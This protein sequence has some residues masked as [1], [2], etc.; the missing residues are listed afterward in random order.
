MKKFRLFLIT[1]TLIFV[2]QHLSATTY[3]SCTNGNWASNST[4]STTSYTSSTNTG[5]YPKA[6]DIVYIGNNFTV[7]I[8]AVAACSTLN[9]VSTLYIGGYN[10]T[11]SG[12]TTISG[13]LNVNAYSGTKIFT[14]LVTVN[15]GGTWNNSANSPVTF[16]GGI[17]NNGTF[18]GTGNGYTFDTNPQSLTGTFDMTG[19]PVVV[20]GITLTNNGTLTLSGNVSGTG[21]LANTSILNST[22][23]ITIAA[24]TNSGTANISAGNLTPTTL[25][26]TGTLN[27]SGT[28]Y[29]SSTTLTNSGT[30]NYTASGNLGAGSTSSFTNTGT[31]NLNGS[32]Y[33]PGITNSTGGIVNFMNAVQSMGTL[34]NN[35]ST[36]ILNISALTTNESFINTLTA[37]ATGNTVNYNGTGSQVIKNTTYYYLNLNGS[38]TKYCLNS[39][40]SAS[41]NITVNTD[42]TLVLNNSNIMGN[43]SKIILNGGTF[44]TGSSS[45]YTETVGTLTLSNNST[46]ALGTGSHSLSFA[47]SSSTTWS[48]TLTITGW[49]GTAGSSGTSG[50]IYVGSDATGLTPYQ[51]S[52]ITF[53][54]YSS[55]ATILS[56]GEVVP[57][58]SALA[59]WYKGDGTYSGGT[60]T[61]VSGKG[62]NAATVSETRT[63]GTITLADN[64]INFNPSLSLSNAVYKLKTASSASVQSVI[65][66]NQPTTSMAADGGLFGYCDYNTG[67]NEI[68]IRM[69]YT[70]QDWTGE[71]NSNDWAYNGSSRING[72]SGY[73]H[74]FKWNIINQIAS[75]AKNYKYYIGGYFDVS[76]GSTWHPRPFYGNVAE[77][78]A[79][80][81]VV[82]NQNNVESYLAVKYGITLSHDYTNGSNSTI[83]SV[84][85]YGYDIAGLGK[86]AT[87]GLN[88]KISTSINVSS[89]S[90]ARV[91]ISTT[92]DY[93]S[94][95]LASS[96]T[97]LANNGQYLIWGHNNGTV[98]TWNSVSGA[99]YKKVNRVWRIQNT[100]EVGAVYMQIDLT[101]FASLPSGYS[102]SVL[103]GNETF[104]TVAGTYKLTNSTGTLYSANIAF[105]A[106]TNYFTIICVPKNYWIGS[107]SDA[108]WSTAT[109]WTAGVVPGTTE[110]VEFATTS[111]YGSAAISDLTCDGDYTINNLTNASSKG[112]IIPAGKSLTVT[113]TITTS[114]GA[115]KIYIQSGSTTPNGTLIFNNPASNP[116]NGTVEVYSKAS[117]DLSGATNNKYKWQ[118]FGIPVAS[119]MAS[120]TF[121]GSYVRQMDESGT[122]ISNHW[123]QMNNSSALTAFTGYEICQS[124]PTTYTVSGQ[125][126]NS[127]FTT[128]QMAYTA[129]AIYPGQHL[130]GNPYTAAIDITKISF[131]TGVDPTVYLYNTG[132]FVAWGAYSSNGSSPGQYTA[133][134]QLTAG[135]G[136]IPSQIPSTQGF[137][138]KTKTSDVSDATMTINYNTALVKNT[139]LKRAPSALKTTSRLPYLKI[140][141]QGQDNTSDVMWMIHQESCTSYFDNGWDGYKM[142]GN[143]YSPQIF[144]NE[145]TDYYQVNSVGNFDQTYI[146]FKAGADSVYTIRLTKDGIDAKYSSLQF[147]D[148]K[149]NIS[150]TIDND[151]V[152][153]KFKASPGELTDKRFMISG[154]LKKTP[155]ITGI[156]VYTFGNTLFVNNYTD[157]NGNVQLYDLTG[158]KL[159]E[160]RFIS[161]T[162]SISTNLPE[163]IY[164]V[165]ASSG[166]VTKSFRVF[167]KKE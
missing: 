130:Y 22:S 124:Q 153:Y 76:W 109:N 91:I 66:V 15:P 145:N 165:K 118:Y 167:L 17:M 163:G 148:L 129:N 29:T 35:T 54:G 23:Q 59:F 159:S 160:K 55:G 34:I 5:T 97:A 156:K 20:T 53:S 141:V 39:T 93:S 13:T 86:D 151:T 155:D 120:P 115:N 2:I 50:K 63:N 79:F 152:E 126:V 51:L 77:V 143:D 32:G 119:V 99:A 18:T 42:N 1:I 94:S 98:T 89:G 104:S 108:N 106:G 87:Y 74:N 47:N 83:Y 84:S 164:I 150:T 142:F 135:T 101:G 75:T 69:N 90:T 7:T 14:G 105:P 62:N 158:R 64:S 107:S 110:D 127:D 121:D 162:T 48:G 61:D 58:S 125:L 25:T 28:T 60:W 46:I 96:R 71:S 112:L 52:C 3:Y 65:I 166:N 9:I 16:R 111:N 154:E 8:A 132:T 26:N 41:G 45:G 134:P 68:G 11:V 72:A 146:G 136:G 12:T 144:A 95:N 43:T 123:I 140:F 122:S 149:E 30:I 44:N 24:L 36:S 147:I 56:T 27:I 161:G 88:Q 21:T 116:V 82:P 100:G 137:L 40:T 85:G 33:I 81:G 157:E 102:Y 133:I 139:E 103:V 114:S 57:T 6:G 128:G 31:I 38:G 138:I 67:N 131:G 37:T 49:A 92:N 10:L 78:M 19:T 117:W 73:V 4:W 70:N 80:S 113:G